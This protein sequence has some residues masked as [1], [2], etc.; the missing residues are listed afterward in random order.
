MRDGYRCA[1]TGRYDATSVKNGV[2]V[3]GNV[4]AMS[5]TQAAHIFP[6]ST[7]QNLGTG[8][9]EGDK[10]RSTMYLFVDGAIYLPGLQRDYAAGVWA[11]MERF[12]R[13]NG[14]LELNG[15]DIH[16]LEN[17]MTMDLRVHG[18]FDCLDLWLE[19]TVTV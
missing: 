8:E 13:V 4:L 16:R 18:A 14:F 6:P 19:A 9:Q 10:V 17:I 3:A 12:G 2:P 1:I 5:Q 7:N 15:P 11:V